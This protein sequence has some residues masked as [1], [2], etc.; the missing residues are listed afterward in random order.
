MKRTAII[1]LDGI[2]SII[3]LG[4]W[5]RYQA[6]KLLPPAESRKLDVSSVKRAVI[7]APHPD[8]EV[9]GA[10]L[11]LNSLVA[12]GAA[13]TIVYA[14]GGQKYRTAVGG[15][16]VEEA[17]AFANHIKAEA[18]F[19]GFGD[20]ELAQSEDMLTKAVQDFLRGAELV[21]VP[22]YSDYHPDHR[23]LSRAVLRALPPTGRLRVLMYCTS[24]PLWPEHKIVYLQDSFTAMNKFFAF[25]RSSTSPR[26][27]N[28]FKI[29]RIFH[30]GRY[31]G[32]RVFWEPY[33]ELE[34]I[35]NARQKAERALPSNFPVLHKPMRWRKFIK[36]L[37]YY[38]KNYNEKV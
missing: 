8:D 22:A 10:G 5:G 29:T 32:E 37:R 1:I 21:V 17:K 28:S 18:C 11:L 31:L 33:W 36:E 2:G 9:Y 24:T 27:I 30:A 3:L 7:F 20:G 23:A 4:P 25:Y 13:V 16:R 26:S 15:D 35:A 14:T 34:G 6:A 19:L 38:K 12:I